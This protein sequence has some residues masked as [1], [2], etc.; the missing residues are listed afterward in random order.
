MAQE[1]E[2]GGKLDKDA[3]EDG[4]N[5]GA[6]IGGIL[7]L[8]LLVAGGV[9]LLNEMSD[10]ARYARCIAARHHNCDGVDYRTTPSE[11]PEKR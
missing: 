2:R 6:T 9:W 3:P 10:N 4:P 11:Q 7:I 5:H 1:T 8:I